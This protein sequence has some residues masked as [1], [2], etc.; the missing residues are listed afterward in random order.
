MLPA[1]AASPWQEVQDMPLTSTVPFTWV[2][3]STEVR[4]EPGWQ[5]PQ[6]AVA[7][8]KG[9]GEGGGLP[10][11]LPQV[12]ST[13]PPVQRGWGWDAPPRVAPWQ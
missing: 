6:L 1:R 8:T 2:A 13:A 12:T 4:V 9:W 5:L 10:W 3:G 7:A 11:Q